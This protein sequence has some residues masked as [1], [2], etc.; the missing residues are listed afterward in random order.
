MERR[1]FL[2]STAAT[3]LGLNLSACGTNTEDDLDGAVI[4]DGKPVTF[5]GMAR[6]DVPLAGAS[7]DIVDAKGKSL[8]DAPIAVT[9]SGLFFCTTPLPANFRLVANSPTAGKVYRE[10]RNHGGTPRMVGINVATHLLALYLDRY[11]TVALVTA[12][13]RV[14]NFLALPPGTSL[15]TGLDAQRGPFSSQV[16]MREARNAGGFQAYSASLVDY[17][18]AGVRRPYTVFDDEEGGGAGT[19]FAST[20][21]ANVLGDLVAAPISAGIAYGANKLVGWLA[22]LMGFHLGGPSLKDISKQLDQVLDQLNQ[23]QQQISAQT[24]TLEYT[25]DQSSLENYV[26]AIVY[27]TN[28]LNAAVSATSG[29]SSPVDPTSN[30]QLNLTLWGTNWGN[31]CNVI[32]DYLLGRNSAPNNM[33]NLYTAIVMGRHGADSQPSLYQGYP[34]RSNALLGQIEQSLVYYLNVVSLGANLMAE[35]SHLCTRNSQ[36]GNFNA[37]AAP[38]MQAKTQITQVVAD[39]KRAAQQ[40]PG[41]LGSDDVLVDMENRVTW[42]LPVWPTWNDSSSYNCSPSSGTYG[43]L[44][45]PNRFQ[46]A[47]KAQLDALRQ[48]LLAM[49]PSAP[50]AALT[51]LGFD[52]ATNGIVVN[53]NKLHVWMYET[54]KNGNRVAG[55]YYRLEDGSTDH[56]KSSDLDKTAYP[57]LQTLSFPLQEVEDNPSTPLLGSAV[58]ALPSGNLSILVDAWGA[59]TLQ[60]LANSTPILGG[61]NFVVNGKGY[62]VPVG[63]TTRGQYD[64]TD[65]VVW[66]SSNPSAAEISNLADGTAGNVTWHPANVVPGSTQ[67]TMTATVFNQPGSPVSTSVPLTAASSLPAAPTLLSIVV[68]PDNLLY[69]LPARNE[70]YQATGFYSDQTAI[71]LSNQVSWSVVDTNTGAAVPSAQA[72]FTTSQKNLLVVNSNTLQSPNLTIKATLG[73]LTG[74]AN[75]QVPIPLTQS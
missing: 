57:S 72:G 75:V 15:D 58:P 73:G 31:S 43:T 65:Y 36:T 6:L 2:G 70:Y 64:V 54:D 63:T 5:F 35:V 47:T 7:L 22:G 40:I 17:I 24:L 69:G 42:Y 53:N 28:A 74:S 34:L 55:A 4:T 13:A 21:F 44:Q 1:V 59:N 68:L 48:R 27:A 3:A 66:S 12:E 49:N 67:V 41:P 37:I 52:L 39:S 50:V 10:V 56:V 26:A 33:V 71:D 18:Y 9:G 23:L 25:T 45:L 46:P 8:L 30:T 19:S 11:P 51:T 32:L 14:R 29:T 61:G 38:I 62:S 60:A 20:V 16:F